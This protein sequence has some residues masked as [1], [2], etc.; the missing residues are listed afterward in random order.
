M[1]ARGR[2][3]TATDLYAILELV[4]ALREAA[5]DLW[6]Y[7]AILMPA[8]AAHPW[9]VGAAFPTDIDGQP[10]GPRGHAIY[11]GWVNAAGLPGL[12]VPAG[13]HGAIPVGL[14]L[15]GPAGHDAALLALARDLDA[16]FTW[17]GFGW[18]ETPAPE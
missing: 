13:L 12:A 14:Q 10:V 7:D 18:T 8:S 9:P 1:A 5:R 15:I 6:G 3:A 4:F 17:P 2:E 11:T 16:P